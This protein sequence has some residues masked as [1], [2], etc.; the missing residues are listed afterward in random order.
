MVYKKTIFRGASRVLLFLEHQIGLQPMS[1]KG[2]QLSIQEQ[3]QAAKAGAESARSDS[4][5][6]LKR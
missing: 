3:W 5:G 6:L 4:G 2:E 1:R